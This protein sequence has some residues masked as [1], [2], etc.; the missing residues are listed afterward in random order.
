MYSAFPRSGNGEVRGLGIGTR[1][2]TQFTC[3]MTLAAKAWGVRLW[4]LCFRAHLRWE[5]T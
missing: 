2:S 4:R 5:S 1:S 3:G